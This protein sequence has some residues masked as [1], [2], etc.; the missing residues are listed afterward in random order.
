MV[1]FWTFNLNGR[2]MTCH[3]KIKEHL[4]WD[5]RLRLKISISDLEVAGRARIR[6]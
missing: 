3:E 1:E 4:F 6:S 2:R 5:V